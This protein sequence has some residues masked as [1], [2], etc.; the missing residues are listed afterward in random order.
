MGTAT[1]GSVDTMKERFALKRPGKL[2]TGNPFVQFD[3]G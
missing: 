2:D 3:E 1:N